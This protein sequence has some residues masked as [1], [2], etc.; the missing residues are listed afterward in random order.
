VL[1][2]SKFHDSMASHRSVVLFFFFFFLSSIYSP[3]PHQK[4]SALMSQAGL[5]LFP[6]PQQYT[7]VPFGDILNTPSVSHDHMH[8]S[9]SSMSPK[10]SLLSL[11]PTSLYTNSPLTDSPGLSPGTPQIH[12]YT[13]LACQYQQCQ[14]ELKKVNQEYA[15]LKYV[16]FASA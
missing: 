10:S 5:P 1:P 7:M 12:V 13:Q 16:S 3:T 15:W 11:A 8:G 9:G 14:E 2:F 4:K 6:I